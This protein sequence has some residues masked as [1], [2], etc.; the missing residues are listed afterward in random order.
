MPTAIRDLDALFLQEHAQQLFAVREPADAEVAEERLGG[1][2]GELDLL[3][4]PGLLQLVCGVEEELVGRAEAACPLAC[5]DDDVAG[6]VQEAL[7]G[8]A[9]SIGLGECGDGDRVLGEAG[10]HVDVVVVAGGDDQVVVVELRPSARVT[11][12]RFGSDGGCGVHELHAVV[13]EGRGDREGDVGGGRVCRRARPDQARVEQELVVFGDDGDVDV[14][15]QFVVHGQGGVR[16]PKLAPRT[17][18][19][20]LD[21]HDLRRPRAGPDLATTNQFSFGPAGRPEQG[22]RSPIAA[23]DGPAGALRDHR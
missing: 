12:W 23:S 10:D 20:F 19:F 6:I 4:Q 18:T 15:V 3:V 13:G 5:G 14:A 8:R 9:C 11:W 7:P 21:I 2:V 17:S 22:R 16:P 1:H